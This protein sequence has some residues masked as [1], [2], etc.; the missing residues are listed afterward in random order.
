MKFRFAALACPLV[1]GV[2]SGSAHAD[3]SPYSFT[4][5]ET[6]EHDSN[7]FRTDAST[8]VA[9]RAA[10][11][12]VTEFRAALDQ[13]L[14]REKLVGAL[15]FDLNRYEGKGLSSLNSNGYQGNLE[16]DWST[17]GDLSGAFGAD[18]SRRQYFYGLN[19][20]TVSTSRN[21][22]TD[23]HVFAR[24]QVGGMG[25]WTVQ[26]GVDANERK[27]SLE[28]FNVN[29]ERQWGANGGVHY[30]TSPDLSFGVTTRYTHGT[31]PNLLLL[32]GDH[33]EFSLRSV[34][35]DTNWQASGNSS[36]QAEVGYSSNHDSGESDRNFVNGS[37]TWNWTPPSHFSV[38]VNLARDSNSD[39]GTA[40]GGAGTTSGVLG[41][42]I[43]DTAR[44][45]VSYSLT[46]KVNLLA[47]AQ[48]TKRDYASGTVFVSG[49][50][51]ILFP[52]GTNRTL[53]FNL[54]ANYQPSRTTQLGCGF[55][56]ERRTADSQLALYAP[57]YNDNTVSCNGSIRFD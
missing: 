34:N 37:L 45:N 3:L 55:T 48:F 19:G 52:G 21:L 56:R 22:Q 25:R 44:L 10:W 23:N 51:N 39:T 18:S 28:S 32:N 8:G 31:Y 41:R 24:A 7:L 15:A 47:G 57:G 12:S 35:L 13:E 43:N 50:N 38:T 4:A 1:L 6:I 36:L 46:S 20:P 9:E 54:S 16:L 27:Y 40:P 14:G 17:I 42:S 33:D 11:L 49:G 30:S 5:S 2:M 29:E 26:G 53:Q